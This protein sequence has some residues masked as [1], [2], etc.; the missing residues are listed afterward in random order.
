MDKNTNPDPEAIDE[1]AR[2]YASLFKDESIAKRYPNRPQ[3]LHRTL[4]FSELYRSLFDPLTQIQKKPTGVAGR[5]K[6]TGVGATAAANQPSKL[7]VYEQKR[8]VIDKFISRW[9]QAVG[10]DF[11]PAMRLILPDRDSDR[12]VYGLKEAAIG[13]LI[14]RLTKIDKNSDDGRSLLHWRV[15][16]NTHAS[17]MAGDFPGR[18]YNVIAKRPMCS[19]PGSMTIADVNEQLDRLAAASGEAEKLAMFE[20]FY[21]RMCPK[22]MLWLIR[23]VLKQMRIGTSTRSLLH[24]WHRDAEALFNVSSSLRRVCW[25][26][27]DPATSL[28]QEDSVVRIGQ[29]FQPQLAQYQMPA[30]FERMV[31]YL[32]P[33]PGDA[34]FWIEE[35]LDGER[36]QMHMQT[37]PQVPGGKRFC[38]FSRRT[39][40]YTYLYGSNLEERDS[41]LTKYLKGCFDERL[42]NVILDGEMIT[43]DPQNDIIMP[44]G[45]L[46]TAA[47][48]EK[49][50]VESEQGYQPFF[51][52]FDILYMNG[53]DLTKYTLRDRRAALEQI[54]R[55]H[56]AET[57]SD[58]DAH[59][60][61]AP[62]K[63]IFRRL[64]VHSY[65][66]TT[67][68]DA[69]E[70]ALRDVIE[71]SS[72]GLVL[73]NP[74][75]MYRLNSRND[76]WLKVKPE[77][78]N[79][80]GESLDCVV[81]GGFFG[82]GRRGNMLASFLCGLRASENHIQAGA[83]PEKCWSFF[84]VGG[85]FNAD[86]YQAIKHH[87][88]GKWMPWDTRNPPTQF[89]ELAGGSRQIE[90]PDM[91]IRPCDSVVLEVKAA[92]VTPS[93]CFAT[94]KT[95]RFP[96]FRRLRLDKSW[97][98][99]L[100]VDE[101]EELNARVNIEAQR[102]EEMTVESRRRA[103]PLKR[104]RKKL[105]IAGAQED[106]EIKVPKQAEVANPELFAGM[107]FCI[108]SDAGKPL[109][110][111]KAE[112]EALV[113]AH[114]GTIK[115]H[116][117]DDKN[118]IL[119]ADR[120]LVPVASAIKKGSFDII[121]PQWLIDCT[122]QAN[123]GFVLPYEAR[124]LLHATSERMAR[125]PETIDRYGDSFA[126]DITLQELR[127]VLAGMTGPDDTKNTA[128]IDFLHSLQEK[129]TDLH[130]GLRG[131]L[132]SGVSVVFRRS[133]GGVSGGLGVELEG[134]LERDE[135]RLSN[136]VRFCSGTI[137]EKLQEGVSH[138]II[139]GD[140]IEGA[141][142]IKKEVERQVAGWDKK[143]AEPAIVWGAWIEECWRKR[144]I[145]DITM[146]SVK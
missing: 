68:P 77:Y 84:R 72:E 123:G 73:K 80:F 64:E 10:P 104:P 48:N 51:I 97:Y 16:G 67:S 50:R 121:Q 56:P 105:V 52:V 79:E 98:S 6:P 144:T 145:S 115:Q 66:K 95:L 114:G 136:Y 107:Q 87:T 28:A 126:R 7:T 93:D 92:N 11:F 101:F 54:V 88:Q 137:L 75:S 47:L 130:S 22:E 20:M 1:D 128:G 13:K 2:Q 30:S 34:E 57:Q 8:H 70:P 135:L 39:K 15:P 113:K 53:H 71:S 86:D 40:D 21:M 118:T 18:C 31:K 49:R 25:E 41:A 119:I 139:I 110:K 112:L 9:R 81:I 94:G 146:Y 35:K 91:W 69:I 83:N 120:K 142:Q 99:A 33:E 116:A 14:V 108:M 32:R 141:R 100:S 60:A 29:C 133:D 140:D 5:S 124:H 44:F 37:D 127:D 65:I 103:R 85:G 122:K 45:T 12:A 102:N 36:M 106:V 38:W 125:V 17:R 62:I 59:I 61:N 3:N 109:K 24:M 138:V 89:I 42:E 129:G 82:S 63:G 58:K 96:R 55:E 131:Y 4:L 78:M 117:G 90:R 27:Y 43:W 132:F 26:L 111:S 46:K 134:I 143:D 76:D 23:I 74:R 19:T